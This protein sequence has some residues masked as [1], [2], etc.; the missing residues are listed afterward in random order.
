MGPIVLRELAIGRKKLLAAHRVGLRWRS[1]GLQSAS[2]FQHNLVFVG[3]INGNGAD[4][5]PFAH[6]GDAIAHAEQFG[7]IA[8]D[9]EDGLT[10]CGEFVDQLIN[11]GFG[12][13]IDA[14]GRLVEKEISTSWS[15][16]RATAIFC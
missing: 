14:A 12:S 1:C 13:D 7:Q 16:S 15:R 4:H 5:S 3:F 11:L 8:A 9:H 6:H 2:G 10:A